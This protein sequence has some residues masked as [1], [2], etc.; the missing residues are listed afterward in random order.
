MPFDHRVAIFHEVLAAERALHR[1][2][3]FAWGGVGGSMSIKARTP[4]SSTTFSV[5]CSQL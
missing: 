4:S 3:E 1:D 2:E 5:K